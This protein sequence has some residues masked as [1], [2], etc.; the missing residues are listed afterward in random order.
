M[1]V[2]ANE[3]ELP[4][5]MPELG[6]AVTSATD[7]T[8]ADT[9][10]ETQLCINGGIILIRQNGSHSTC[11]SIGQSGSD[12]TI[13]FGSTQIMLRDNGRTLIISN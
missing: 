11:I 13:I 12:Q 6:E 4:R 8:A 1:V 10:S 7:G 3:S 2:I 9:P 5:M